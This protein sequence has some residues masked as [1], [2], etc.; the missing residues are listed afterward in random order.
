MF[1][2]ILSIIFV[3][4]FAFGQANIIAPDQ[5]RTLKSFKNYVVNPDADKNISDGLTDSSSIV[6]RVTG[7]SRLDG[8][9][10]YQIDGTASGQIVRFALNALPNKFLGANAEFSFNYSYTT[11]NANGSYKVYVENSVGAKVS[12]E[13]NLLSTG[14]FTVPFVGYFT[15]G[16][17]LSNNYRIAIEST[18]S[19]PEAMLADNFYGGDVT[20]IG[21]F[22]AVSEW[23]SVPTAQLAAG[24]WVQG[25]T[26]N[27]TYSSTVTVNRAEWRRNGPDLEVNWH[28]VQTAGTGG[29][30]G[31]GQYLLNIAA[32]NSGCVI[33]TAKVTAN[34]GVTS[35]S[36]TMA[37]ITQSAS[38]VGTVWFRGDNGGG[39]K[40]QGVGQASV[41]D[42]TRLKVDYIAVWADGSVRTWPWSNAEQFLF[43]RELGVKANLSIPCQGWSASQSAAAANQT[44]FGPRSLGATTITAVSVNPTKGTIVTDEIVAERKGKFLIATY[45]LDMS[46]AGTGGTGDY[47]FQVPLGLSI[48]TSFNPIYTGVIGARDMPKSRMDATGRMW[49]ST[50]ATANFVGAIPY[51]ATTFRMIIQS[52]Y[53]AS[54]F[55]GSGSFSLAAAMGFSFT[56]KIPIQ[57]WE[58]N[59]RAPTLIGSVTSNAV[60]AERIERARITCGSAGSTVLGQS[61]GISVANGAGVGLCDVT[62]TP[63][64]S[65]EPSCSVQLRNA[66]IATFSGT[67]ITASSASGISI[68]R[69]V[70]GTN[71][72][73]D[74]HL[75][76]MGPR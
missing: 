38:S 23:Q 67:N 29:A 6:T 60:G 40:Q 21:Q 7:A 33:D 65:A 68:Q 1:N 12:P 58:D 54:V 9:A 31:S 44:D 51:T 55:Q 49:Q 53:S 25:S 66:A 46:G 13:Y 11:S 45:R 74:V 17:T 5:V 59:Q 76:C 15:P 10:S 32:L 19:A 2:R 39:I 62:F 30:N 57:G 47:L 71:T 52:E 18:V 41:F 8:Q 27:P 69:F 16:A 50:P 24:T 37:P 70:N 28:F 36:S 34:N 72:T 56:V 4:A 42:S 14:G 3:S 75:I 64:F 61:A 63:A 43:N 20:S 22:S 73:G 35:A 26:T 48:D